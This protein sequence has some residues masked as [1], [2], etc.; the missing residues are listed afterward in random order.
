MVQI[1]GVPAGLPQQQS[2]FSLSQHGG[3]LGGTCSLGLLWDE[4]RRAVVTSGHDLALAGVPGWGRGW[5]AVCLP[6]DSLCWSLG[7]PWKVPQREGFKQQ[8]RIVR[9]SWRPEV[10]DACGCSLGR[11]ARVSAKLAP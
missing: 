11:P 10:R 2:W 6:C 3:S 5:G 8:K 7:L 4:G 9:Q 1:A